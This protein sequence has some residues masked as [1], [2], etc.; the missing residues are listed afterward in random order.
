MIRCLKHEVWP[1]WPSSIFFL[2][3][4]CN[5]VDQAGALAASGGDVL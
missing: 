4:R 1:W 5:E 2:G 3:G